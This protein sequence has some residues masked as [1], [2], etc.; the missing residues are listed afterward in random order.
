MNYRQ[1]I[2]TPC[3]SSPR[4]APSG[5][6]GELSQTTRAHTRARRSFTCKFWSL[7]LSHSRITPKP[8]PCTQWNPHPHRPCLGSLLMLACMLACLLVM[9]QSSVVRM[10]QKAILTLPPPPGVTFGSSIH[11][12]SGRVRC[13]AYGLST[14]VCPSPR[15]TV[16]LACSLPSMYRHPRK[17]LSRR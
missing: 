16:T 2:H 7:Q 3:G 1:E 8:C 9:N 14:R 13:H 4:S 12:A 6:G 11:I 15:T 5:G 17:M 10:R